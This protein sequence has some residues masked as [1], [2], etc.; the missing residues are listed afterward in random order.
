MTDGIDAMVARS[1]SVSAA[2]GE[3]PGLEKLRARREL[4]RRLA[5]AATVPV[6]LATVADGGRSAKASSI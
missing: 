5:A 3:A 2:S 4:I 1:D 6:V